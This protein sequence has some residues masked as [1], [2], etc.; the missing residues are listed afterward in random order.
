V[1][2]LILFVSA[3]CLRVFVADINETRLKMA[4]EMG[5]D[6]VIGKYLAPMFST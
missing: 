4:S 6:V 2:V 1:V 3:G 5:A